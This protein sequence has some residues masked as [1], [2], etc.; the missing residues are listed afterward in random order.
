MNAHG[1]DNGARP[2]RHTGLIV[3]LGF[4]S[5]NALIGG[6]ALILRPDGGLL[7]MTPAELAT[8]LFSDFRWPGLFLFT[9]FGVGGMVALSGLLGHRRWGPRLAMFIGAAQVVW[10]IV[11]VVLIKKPSLLQ[12]LLLLIGVII[13]AL[14]ARANGNARRPQ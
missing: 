3:L 1:P 11:Q 4:L 7:G 10:I 13:T 14:A 9:L 6:G 12:P 8:S 5:I 2:R